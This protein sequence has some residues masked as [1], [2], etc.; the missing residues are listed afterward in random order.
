M[1]RPLRPSP[2]GYQFFPVPGFIK[3]IPPLK[4]S[5]IVSAEMYSCG[6]TRQRYV[7]KHMLAENQDCS[8]E[9]CN[10]QSTV[11]ADPLIK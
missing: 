3:L 1:F 6:T 11:E 5:C 9:Y 2:D 8:Y 10:G 4:F 7:L